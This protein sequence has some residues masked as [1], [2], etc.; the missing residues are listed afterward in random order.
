MLPINPRYNTPQTRHL[1]HLLYQLVWLV[2]IVEDCGTTVAPPSMAVAPPTCGVA[3]PTTGIAPPIVHG[4][5]IIRVMK[6]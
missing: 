1:L 5:T 2:S 4:T 3:P 6:S